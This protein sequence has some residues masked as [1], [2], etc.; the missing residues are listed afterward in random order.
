MSYLVLSVGTVVVLSFFAFAGR[1]PGFTVLALWSAGTAY[2]V[3]APVYS[4]RVSNPR[5]LAALALYGTVGLVFARTTR[6]TRRRVRNEPGDEPNSPGLES[7]PVPRVE[8]KRVLADLT[9]SSE[10]G[11]RLKQRRIEVESSHLGSFR[12]SHADAVRV[13]SHMF[14]AVLIDP[15]LRRVSFHVSRRPGIALLFVDA[16][17]SWPSPFRKTITIGKSVEGCSRADFHGWPD[18]LSATWFDNGYGRIYQVSFKA[19]NP[20]G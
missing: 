4:F 2:F 18:D 17:R 15:Q 10:L 3:M 11:E 12:C 1:L 8:I 14:A 19:A 6:R 16:H 9:S 7:P 20:H 13:L 5:D